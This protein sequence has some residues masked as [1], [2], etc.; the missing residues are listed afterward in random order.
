[1]FPFDEEAALADLQLIAPPDD[2]IAKE[3]AR[4][5]NYPLSYELTVL[6]AF[7]ASACLQYVAGLPELRDFKL[8]RALT[9]VQIRLQEH[10][11]TVSSPLFDFLDEGWDLGEHT[12][13]VPAYW[14]DGVPVYEVNDDEGKD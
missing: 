5:G 8:A 14:I 13:K 6:E 11:G 7:L 12:L 10:I 4:L 9:V 3:L 2:P 1:M